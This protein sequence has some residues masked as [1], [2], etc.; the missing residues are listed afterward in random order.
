VSNYEIHIPSKAQR[1]LNRLPEKVRE[2]AYAFIYGPLAENPQRVGHALHAPFEGQHTAYRGAYRIT[3][4]IH[5]DRVLV[6]VVSAA[7][8]SDIYRT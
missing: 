8:R 6:E 1:S 3:Y 2:A 4:Q 5:E 7:H